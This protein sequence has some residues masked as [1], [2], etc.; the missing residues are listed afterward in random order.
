MRFISAVSQVNQWRNQSCKSM[1]SSVRSVNDESIRS[2]N[3][4]INMV[5]SVTFQSIESMASLIQIWIDIM[6]STSSMKN[7]VRFRQRV[8]N[9]EVWPWFVLRLFQ[10]S[11]SWWRGHIASRDV[12]GTFPVKC[13]EPMDD[14]DQGNVSWSSSS[15]T[16]QCGLNQSGLIWINGRVR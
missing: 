5:S 1:T 9:V 13:T 14:D 3:D 6:P 10:D 7:G 15:V 8:R 11:E 2:V 16:L 12:S 4:V